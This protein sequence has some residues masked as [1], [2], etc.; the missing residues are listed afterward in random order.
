V[1]EPAAHA[2]ADTR[3]LQMT[4]RRRVVISGALGAVGA[5]VTAA[6][7]PWQLAILMGWD[8]TAVFVLAT[9]WIRVLRLDPNETREHAIAEDNS[10]TSAELL[11]LS[12]S[13]TTLVGV[14]FGLAKA[15]NTTGAL[16]VVLTIAGVL[17]VALSWFVV[18]TVF[19]LRYAHEYYTDP[20]GGID[21]KTDEQP[22]YWDFGYVAATIGMTFQV[23]DTDIQARK[24]R[25]TILRHALLSYLFGAVILAVTVNVIANLLNQ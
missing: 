21:F 19:M 15:N 23:S 16:N 17:T 22:D 20:V 6:L 1:S 12:A 8:V 7:A 25:R 11:L 9:V 4:A 13:V 3:V 14:A 5:A 10:R 2:A 18:H 24:V